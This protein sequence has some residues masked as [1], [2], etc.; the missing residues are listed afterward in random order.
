MESNILDCTDVNRDYIDVDDE[1]AWED[2][3]EDT[4]RE[5]FKRYGEGYEKKIE[6]WE[7]TGLREAVENNQLE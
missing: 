2:D 5:V 7:K 4:V 1:D 6:E 3:E